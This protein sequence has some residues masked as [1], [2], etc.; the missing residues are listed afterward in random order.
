MRGLKA[1]LICLI[2]I[3]TLHSCLN[4]VEEVPLDVPTQPIPAPTGLSA[5]VADREISLSWDS[6]S[7]AAEY[8]LYRAV[9]DLGTY[10]RLAQT[11]NTFYTDTDVRSGQAYYYQ[12]SSVTS[13]GIEGARSAELRAVPSPYTMAINGGSAYTG[14]SEVL[15]EL[16]APVSTAVMK[17]SN[18]PELTGAVWEVFS[19]AKSWRLTGGDG[20]KTVYALFRDENDTLSPIIEASITLDT[21]ALITDIMI[22]PYD[23]VAPGSE[24][25]FEMNV[26]DDETEG[27]GWITIEDMPGTIPLYDDGRWGDGTAGDGVYGAD[28][29]FPSTVRGTNLMITGHFTDRAGNNSPEFE[30]SKTLSFTDPPDPVQLIGVI[31]STTSSITIQWTPS[32][33]DNFASYRIYRAT[34]TGVSDLPDYF[35]KELFNAPQSTYPDGQLKEGET[36]YYR[37]YVVNDL[38]ETAGSNELPASTFD[39]VPEAV[40]L[41]TLSSVGQT[42]VTLTWSMNQNTDFESYRIYRATSPGVTLSSELIVTQS[43]REITYFDDTGLDLGSNTYYYRVYVFD[44]SGKNSRSNEVSTE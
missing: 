19:P 23:L 39:A 26:E 12:V 41:D 5:R 14:D 21:Y 20:V 44:A 16:T 28:Y 1:L 43:N 27:S 13:G 24:V 38:D 33:D 3:G 9:G 10:S 31:D 17:I 4:D 30:A 36:Y 8:R 18:D 37:I 42:R 22:D 7:T 29:T 2:L 6:V 40:V 15:L 35:V 25:H 11:A 32:Q 34:E